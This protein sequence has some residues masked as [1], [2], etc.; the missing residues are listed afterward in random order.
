MRQ[1][2]GVE[3]YVDAFRD[4]SAS[5]I[6]RDMVIEGSISTEGKTTLVVAGKIRG[7]VKTEGD[8]VIVEGGS[9]LGGAKCSRLLV[10]GSLLAGDDKTAE[11]SCTVLHVASN[12][13][14]DGEEMTVS[15]G[16]VRM[17]PGAQIR[18][19]LV[20]S[21]QPA[22]AS[23]LD[24][25]SPAPSLGVAPAL[26][27]IAPHEPSEAAPR[28][29]TPLARP[30]ASGAALSRTEAFA[31]AGGLGAGTAQRSVAGGAS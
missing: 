31:Q 29:V 6:S 7:S 17:D 5:L 21:G 20:P 2:D 16:L 8:V 30:E 23:L 27:S 11:V 22:E 15:Y 9:V 3:K 1:T 14:I 25:F 26:R 13:R 10:A 19:R 4:G 18:A 28:S 24:G 12:G